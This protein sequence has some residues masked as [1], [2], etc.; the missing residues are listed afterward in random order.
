MHSCVH[1]FLFDPQITITS[2]RHMLSA[3]F[4]ISPKFKGNE[5]EQT[6]SFDKLNQLVPFIEMVQQM[7]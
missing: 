1:G 3:A 5:V 2:R 6:V 7:H 4:F